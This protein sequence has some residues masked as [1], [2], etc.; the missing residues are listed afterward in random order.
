MP[1]YPFCTELKRCTAQE[2]PTDEE[3][4]RAGREEHQKKKQ[5]TLEWSDLEG[6][7][8]LP[9]TYLGWIWI[10]RGRGK[11]PDLPLRPAEARRQEQAEAMD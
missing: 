5:S 9:R 2:D 11:P 3:R 7:A 10:W 4:S 6:W 8:T 1:V